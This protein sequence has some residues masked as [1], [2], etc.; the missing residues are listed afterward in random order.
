MTRNEF[1]L[2][3][4]GC[5]VHREGW[6]WRVKHIHKHQ[7]RLTVAKMPELPVPNERIRFKSYKFFDYVGSQKP[8]PGQNFW[9][10]EERI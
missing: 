10:E 2:L 1:D 5:V 6:P 7:G 3:W 4:V 9:E 8:P